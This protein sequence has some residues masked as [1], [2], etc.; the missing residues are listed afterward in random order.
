MAERMAL[1]T[2]S[3]TTPSAARAGRAVMTGGL[4]LALLWGCGGNP[5]DLPRA[6]PTPAVSLDTVATRLEVPWDL[7]FA[8]DGRIFMTERPGRIRVIENGMLRPEPWAGFDVAQRSEMGL[9][10]I[11][12]APDFAESGHVFVAGSFETDGGTENRIYRLTDTGGSGTDQRLILG[13][14]PA[15]RFHAGAALDFGPDGMLYLTAGDALDPGSAQKPE[16]LSGKILRIDP[17]GGVPAGN[18]VAGSYV[19]ALGVRNSQGLAWHPATGHLFAA[20]HGPSGLP[21]EWFRTGRDELNVV[22]PGANYGWP[23]AAGVEKGGEYM[24]PL[25]EWTPAIAPG[26]IAFYTG[27]DFPWQGDLFIAALKGRALLRITLEPAAGERA[28]W[29]AT[30]RETLFQNQLGRIRAVAMGPDGALYFT[31]SNRDG[32]G[33]PGPADDLLLRVV[34]R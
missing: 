29:R 33:D 31:T 3:G 12:I 28:R 21:K 30:G 11:A 16:S 34:R 32:R 14:I 27:D 25:I 22:L 5:T 26:G 8:P 7:D 13:G 15:A 4:S 20:G 19:Y 6:V 1:Q 9:M 17:D 10:G 23:D 24:L 2:A 18:P